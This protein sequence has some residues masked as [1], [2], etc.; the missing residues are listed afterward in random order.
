MPDHMINIIDPKTGDQRLLTL[1]LNE[2]QI[3][4]AKRS[5]LRSDPE[6]NRQIPDGYM[7]CDEA[8]A[9]P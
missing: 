7:P 1:Q 9:T 8:F 5:C 2:L 6:I 3:A 4:Q